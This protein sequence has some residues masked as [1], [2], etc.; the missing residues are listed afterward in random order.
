MRQR[1]MALWGTI[2]ALSL[3]CSGGG[4]GGGG[5]AGASGGSSGGAGTAGSAAV[6]GSA[7][8]GGAAGSAVAGSGG[9]GTGAVWSSLPA[10]D[11]ERAAERR[12]AC[13][14][15]CQRD[16]ACAFWDAADCMRNCADPRKACQADL[17]PDACWTEMVAFEACKATL[18]CAELNH[19]YYNA[20]TAD[21]PCRDEATRLE[22]VCGFVELVAGTECYG[23]NF[24]CADGSESVSPYW[25]CDGENDCADDSDEANCPWLTSGP[26]STCL[27]SATIDSEDSAGD[28]A[29]LA[30][31]T[32]IDGPLYVQSSTLTTLAGL[33]A[34]T[35][36][37]ELHIG[38]TPPLSFDALGNP[39]LVSLAGLEGLRGVG[40]LTIEGNPVLTDLTALA[41]LT[42]MTGEL[43][44]IE[45]TALASLEGLHNIGMS[46]RITIGG[47]PAL[48]SL[49]GLRGLTSSDGFEFNSNPLVTNFTGLANLE[50]FGA[51]GASVLFNAG[52]VDFTGL[53]SLR[54]I[55]AGF[56]VAGNDALVSFAGLEAVERLAWTVRISDNPLLSSIG[57]LESLTEIRGDVTI[58]DNPLLPTCAVDALLTPLGKTCTCSGND[59]AASCL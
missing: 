57:E 39:S 47:N 10:G 17:A 43:N 55:G 25:V 52:L 12:A 7:G 35:A 59:D 48:A 5:G 3:A 21:R 36:V 30:G 14:A 29:A 2:P 28:V 38:G 32:C 24:Q 37:G 19:F 23:P 8:T 56:T 26:E 49:D 9:Q 44:V 54:S 15:Q 51:E 16:G 46:G 45:N 58:E 18:D 22:E 53:T 33:E 42:F 34:L 41:G 40:H 4:D 31:I 13:E 6:S 50:Y 20:S 27:E 11:G 1:W